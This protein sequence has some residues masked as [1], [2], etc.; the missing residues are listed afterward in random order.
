MSRFKATSLHMMAL[1]WVGWCRSLDK[2]N[3]AQNITPLCI[4]QTLLDTDYV[5]IVW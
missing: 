5:L 3:L 4:Q 2:T 1:Q